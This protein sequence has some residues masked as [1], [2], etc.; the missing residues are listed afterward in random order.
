M[1]K[2]VFLRLSNFISL[3]KQTNHYKTFQQH[4][5]FANVE[6]I[7]WSGCPGNQAILVNFDPLQGSGDEVHCLWMAFA[8]IRPRSNGLK[9]PQKLF[10]CPSWISHWTTRK[11][12]ALCVLWGL[13]FI[14]FGAV[15]ATVLLIIYLF[16]SLMLLIAPSPILTL[17]L[18][19]RRL[20]YPVTR[21]YRYLCLLLLPFVLVCEGFLGVALFVFFIPP[22]GFLCAIIE[23]TV[24]G[25]VLNADILTSYVAFSLWLQQTFISAMLTY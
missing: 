17:P 10:A 4:L 2:I 9:I 16:V 3:H 25:L 5:N 24:S 12:R 19:I 21:K 1:T 7:A 15:L 18:S 20:T 6:A 23:F 14:L 22:A 13:F 11:R 8:L